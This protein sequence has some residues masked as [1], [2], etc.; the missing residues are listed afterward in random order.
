[1][2]TL[3]VYVSQLR[4]ILE[5]GVGARA[6]VLQTRPPGYVAVVSE[7]QLDLPRF[8]GL[9]VEG[10]EALLA[11]EL[12]VAAERL[13]SALA[14][15]RGPCL[16]EVPL[17]ASSQAAI[18]GLEELRL[19]AH[20]DLIVVELALGRHAAV[21]PELEALVAE[22]PY[23]ESLRGHLML[24]LYRSGRQVDALE[25]FRQARQVLVDELGIEP[26]RELQRLEQAILQHEPALDAVPRAPKPPPEQLREPLVAAPDQAERRKHVAVAVIDIVVGADGG[27]EL[28]PELVSRASGRAFEL[29]AASAARHHGL[30]YRAAGGRVITVFGAASA[31]EDDALRATRAV[32]DGGSALRTLAA[33]LELDVGVRLGLHAGIEAGVALVGR[34]DAGDLSISGNVLFSAERAAV[35]AAN[36][37]I[38]IGGTLRLVIAAQPGCDT[39]PDRRILD[40]LGHDVGQRR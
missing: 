31:H 26:N 18:V 2:N 16:A 19:A 1:M 38:V 30:V 5:P 8:E 13:R 9:L 32:V 34:D 21:V 28:D 33:E 29:V 3:Q 24:A 35:S 40:Q 27:R 17:Q 14:L 4:K 39:R 20:E 7:G 10:R 37:E 6:R 12:E 22:H 11:D 36:D 23:R 15:W 25:A